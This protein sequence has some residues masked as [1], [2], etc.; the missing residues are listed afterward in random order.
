MLSLPSPT[1]M[2]KF[3]EY[4]LQARSR[5]SRARRTD[6]ASNCAIRPPGAPNFARRPRVSH[7]A[8]AFLA[9]RADGS[10]DRPCTLKRSQPKNSLD[11]PAGSPTGTLLRLDETPPARTCLPSLPTRG[12]SR[13][14]ATAGVDAYDGQ[15]EQISGTYSARFDEARLREVPSSCGPFQP[16]I[17]TT[18]RFA[19]P[20]PPSR[21][22]PPSRPIV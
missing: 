3:G 5:R 6:S 22:P 1:N 19:G 14:L 15:C 8:A 13:Q 12:R 10:T 20:P 4:P 7:S 16:T 2:L 11:P 18:G 17:P 21:Q 9:L